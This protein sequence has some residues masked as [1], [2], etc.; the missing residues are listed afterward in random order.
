MTYVCHISYNEVCWLLP[1][2]YILDSQGQ[3]CETETN[4]RSQLKKTHVMSINMS[5]ML[6]VLRTL[7]ILKSIML[8][9]LYEVC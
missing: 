5:C 4:K 3:M 2:P 8:M 1:V 7:D 6:L 9:P